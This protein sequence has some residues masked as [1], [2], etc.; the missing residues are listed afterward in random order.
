M[1]TYDETLRNKLNSALYVA[2]QH[3]S[4]DGS[5]VRLS[6]PMLTATSRYRRASSLIA[7]A[8]WSGC[9]PRSYVKGAQVTAFPMWPSGFGDRDDRPAVRGRPDHVSVRQQGRAAGD[10]RRSAVWRHTIPGPFHWAGVSDQYFAAVFLPQDP[11][12]AAHGDAAQRHSKFRTMRPIANNKQ[13]D[14]VDVLGAAVG[15]LKGATD[16]RLYVGPKALSDLEVGV[17]ARALPGRN[18]ICGRSLISA[19]WESSRGRCF[20]G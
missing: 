8:M 11:Q 7:T 2:T 19:G 18:R 16:A 13:K 17:G 14:K 20:C 5:G 15:S 12:N 10:Q 1:W 9:R 6:L 3:A 4:A